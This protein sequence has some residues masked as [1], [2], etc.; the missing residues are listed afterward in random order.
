MEQLERIYQWEKCA[1]CS[2]TGKWSF[3][4][5]QRFSCVV[6]GGKGQ[7]SVAQP[8]RRCRGCGGSG[9][10]NLVKPCLKCAGAG[11]EGIQ[12]E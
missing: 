10:L 1:F 8:A 3:A 4:P 7:V 11:W 9:S 5:G 2:G 6:C 12:S